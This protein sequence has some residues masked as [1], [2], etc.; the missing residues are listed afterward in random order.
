MLLSQGE[1]LDPPQME[2]RNGS[3]N[4]MFTGY[5]KTGLWGKSKKK[6]EWCQEDRKRHC[7]DG[8]RAEPRTPPLWPRVEDA[9]DPENQV[10]SGNGPG[11]LPLEKPRG[12]GS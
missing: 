1:A 11:F 10:G 4:V 5:M 7:W 8:A 2:S 12:A 6:K 9:K 3:Q